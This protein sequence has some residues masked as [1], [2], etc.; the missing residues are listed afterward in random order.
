[1]KKKKSKLSKKINIAIIIILITLISIKLLFMIIEN[2][3][4]TDCAELLSKETVQKIRQ[5]FIY[6]LC[7][8]ITITVL[9][10]YLIIQAIKSKKTRLIA[11]SLL[12]IIPIAFG[13]KETVSDYQSMKNIEEAFKE[14]QEYTS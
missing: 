13:T 12:T 9:S 11:V 3:T 2:Y 8:V 5:Q 7:Y 6:N 4:Q 10:V 1:M 14:I